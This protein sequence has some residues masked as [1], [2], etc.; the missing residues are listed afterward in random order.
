MTRSFIE[1]FLTDWNMFIQDIQMF[2]RSF[3]R[4]CCEEEPDMIIITLPRSNSGN[5]R[6]IA[7][8]IDDHLKDDYI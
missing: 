8:T 2:F 4:C 1:Q 5:T 7:Y 3:C 6:K